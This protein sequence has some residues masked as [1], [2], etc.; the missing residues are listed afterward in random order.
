MKTLSNYS[1][2]DQAA[3]KAGKWAIERTHSRNSI[4]AIDGG[5]K[6]NVEENENQN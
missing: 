2:S 1:P 6:T 5:I 4:R 3:I